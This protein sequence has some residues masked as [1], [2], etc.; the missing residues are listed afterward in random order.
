M[1]GLQLSVELHRR[2]AERIQ[3]AEPGGTANRLQDPLG[4][5]PRLLVADRRDCG[6]V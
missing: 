2:F 1:P 4:R 3:K 6:E 5:R